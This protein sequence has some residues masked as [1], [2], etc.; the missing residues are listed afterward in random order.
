M[1]AG[2]RRWKAA[3]E[4]AGERRS[5]VVAIADMDDLLVNDVDSFP[6]EKL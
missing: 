2:E 5:E 1:L 4:E 3:V 6:N